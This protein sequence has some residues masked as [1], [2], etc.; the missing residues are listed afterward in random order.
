M[1]R[2]L[3]DT[4]FLLQCIRWKIDVFTE[5]ERLFP[6]SKIKI[7]VFDR[8]LEELQGKKDSPLA[9]AFTKRME[10]IKTGSTLP[11]DD[12]LLEHGQETDTVVATQDKALKEKLK[13]ASIPIITIRKQRYLVM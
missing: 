13:K 5:L 10:L 1:H 12:L 7:C 6:T 3:L 4:D 9:L 8:T 11:V 2:I